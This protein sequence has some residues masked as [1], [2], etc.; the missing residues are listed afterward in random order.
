MLDMELGC[1]PCRAAVT[2]AKGQ[3]QRADLDHGLQ[4]LPSDGGRTWGLSK[5]CLMAGTQMFIHLS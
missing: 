4:D 2:R 1:H 5:G 3:P